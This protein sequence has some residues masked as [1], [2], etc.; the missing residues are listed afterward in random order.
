MLFDQRKPKCVVLKTAVSGSGKYKLFYG[1]HFVKGILCHD[2]GTVNY[3]TGE[4]ITRH[5]PAKAEC[6][7]IYHEYEKFLTRKP[8]F[9]ESEDNDPRIADWFRRRLM[10]S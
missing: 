6:L 7:R 5:Y 9:E 1:H 3:L 2:V 4:I 8:V 10:E